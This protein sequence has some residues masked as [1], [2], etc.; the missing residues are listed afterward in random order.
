VFSG[1]YNYAVDDKGRVGLPACLRDA[2]KDEKHETLFIT[3]FVVGREKIL[4]LFVPSEWQRLLTSLREKGR[5]NPDIQRFERFYIG[6]AHEVPL[7]KQG[8]ILIP[9]HLRD[10]AGLKGEVTFSAN[11]DHFELWDKALLEKELKASE[12][13]LMDPEFFAKLGIQ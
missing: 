5:F 4:Q 6:G 1:R 11:H 8:R 3:N 10:H 9:Q 13:M 7:D 2:L 12:E